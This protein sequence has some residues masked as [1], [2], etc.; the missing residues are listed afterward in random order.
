LFQK[1]FIEDVQRILDQEGVLVL[2][3]E[4][5]LYHLDCSGGV[6][7]AVGELF[8]IAVPYWSYIPTYP[9]GQWIFILGSKKY[10][11]LNNFRESEAR[12][13][14]GRLKYYN[15]EIHKAAFSLPNFVKMKYQG[16]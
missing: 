6:L 12:A 9:S 4:S 10:C 14:S 7:K 15:S 16:G 1:P 2:Q 11:P 3:A 13:I 5:A 8:P